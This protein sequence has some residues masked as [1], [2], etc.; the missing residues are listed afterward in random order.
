MA[1]LKMSTYGPGNYTWLTGVRRVE[2]LFTFP[3]D[4]QN[5][6]PVW[7]VFS[8]ALSNYKAENAE[9]VDLVEFKRREHE[10]YVAAERSTGQP[11][12]FL[13]VV[14]DAGDDVKCQNWLVWADQNYLLEN[15][16]TIDRI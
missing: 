16:K 5:S 3:T 9:L 13:Y 7:E 6:E 1:T 8:R 4:K 2:R 15:G 10:N 12:S 11:M 14:L